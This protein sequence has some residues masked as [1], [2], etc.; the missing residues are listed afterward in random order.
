MFA[1]LGVSMTAVAWHPFLERF[2]R[3]VLADRDQRAAL[4]PQVLTPATAEE[5][6]T[7]EKR[8]GASLPDCYRTFLLTTNGWRTAGAFVYDLLPAAEVTWFRDSHN[9]WLDAWEEGARTVGKPIPVSDEEYSVYGPE[10]NSCKFRDEYWRA[11]L[12]IS[13]IGDSAIYLLNPLVVTADGEWEAWCFANWFPGARRHRTFWELM[14]HELESFV[15]LREQSERRYFP[16]DGIETL[17]PKIP[18]LI[19]ELA[20]KAQGHRQ[21]QEQRASRGRSAGE[22]YTDGIIEA[23]NAAEEAVERIEVLKIP[24]DAL[25]GQ[26]TALADDLEQQ[27]KTNVR[28]NSCGVNKRDGRAE[29]NRE[30]TGIIRWFLNQPQS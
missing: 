24:S 9:D 17:L 27:W 2:S 13:G 22:A 21:G 16:Q 7:L 4:P 3:E 15:G 10:Q 6:A 8:L 30:A 19:K 5:I 1:G 23:L 18:G 25:L 28:P 12:A 26:L 14:Q 11:T 20:E 29:G